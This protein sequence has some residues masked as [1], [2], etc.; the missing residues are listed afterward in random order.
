[1]GAGWVAVKKQ[2]ALRRQH[3]GLAEGSANLAK[4]GEG[5]VVGGEGGVAVGL[6]LLD[7]ADGLQAGGLP[8][9]IGEPLSS[10][11]RCAQAL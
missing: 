1:M 10:T 3:I 6:E 9:T 5:L 11:E 8:L 2:S 7:I 4:E